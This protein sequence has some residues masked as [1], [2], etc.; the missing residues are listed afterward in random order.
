MCTDPKAIAVCR[1]GD[2]SSPPLV[3]MSLA[4]KTVVNRATHVNEIVMVSGIVQR[5]VEFDALTPTPKAFDEYFTALCAPAPPSGSAA[6][7]AAAKGP[8]VTLPLDFKAATARET[9]MRTEAN[10]R[11]VLNLLLA[12]LHQFDP[13]VLVGHNLYAFALDILM[14][15]MQH[16]QI[17]VWHKLGR[18]RR[19]KRPRAGMG[20][21]GKESYFG[22][23]APGRLLVDS[24]L[25]ARELVREK[26]RVTGVRTAV[27]AGHSAPPRREGVA[28]VTAPPPS[29]PPGI[30]AVSPLGD[31]PEAEAL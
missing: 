19:S 22:A 25:T 7:A 29:L 14:H 5:N 13:D 18:L 11:G 31:L 3:V 17:A 20:A 15:R 26:V 30:H 23:L 8:A 4:V 6:A 21:G 24:Y 27:T 12:K 1:D 16:H 28:D 2:L 9:R 10:E